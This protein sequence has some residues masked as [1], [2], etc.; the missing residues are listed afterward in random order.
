MTVPATMVVT[1]TEVLE[2]DM[3]AELKVDTVITPITADNLPEGPRWEEDGACWTAI[4]CDP[5]TVGVDWR[6]APNNLKA[7]EKER[8]TGEMLDFVWP[9]LK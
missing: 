1:D 5:S 3:S 9:R 2:M 6:W 8:P 4:K 7:F